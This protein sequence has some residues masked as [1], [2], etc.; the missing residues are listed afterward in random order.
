MTVRFLTTETRRR[1][2]EIIE[3][4]GKGETVSLNERIKLKKYAVHIP[5]V[6]GKITQAMR[7][8]ERLDADG[9]V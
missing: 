7:K 1:I 9:L 5:F 8:R 3:R 6:A 4:L 2:E